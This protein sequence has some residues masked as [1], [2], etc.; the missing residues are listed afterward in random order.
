MQMKN[1]ILAFMLLLAVQCAAQKITTT[2][3]GDALVTTIYESDKGDIAKDWKSLMKKYDAKVDISSDK[4][5]AKGAVIKTMS[6]GT[7]DVSAT[8]E[9]IKDGEVKMVVIFDPIAS[10]DSKTPE[11]SVYIAEAK[12]IVQDFAYKS[13]SESISDLV[14]TNQKAYD[15]LV[16]QHNGL[17]RDNEN[18]ASDIE[19]Y[20]KKITNDERD[21]SMNKDK[22]AAKQKEEDAQKA[23]LDAVIKRQKALN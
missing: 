3:T 7:F 2:E 21:I 1:S 20:K 10:A 8:V 15:K 19:S 23:S 14:K 18:L 6:S 17:V 12:R 22:I 13:S 11:R 4:I 9:K 16:K 5:T